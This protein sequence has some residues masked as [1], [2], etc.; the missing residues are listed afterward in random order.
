MIVE[1]NR[2]LSFFRKSYVF[3]PKTVALHRTI[4]CLGLTLLASDVMLAQ[5]SI[6]GKVSS[7]EG[8]A[9]FSATVML[10]NESD[11]SLVK[12][13]LSDEAGNYRFEQVETGIYLLSLEYVGYEKTYSEPIAIRQFDRHNQRSYFG[14]NR[15]GWPKSIVRKTD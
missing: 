14:R 9:L 3:K 5:T 11:S 13:E 6:F 4:L 1:M 2:L 12:G 10:L 7:V 15:G 8:E